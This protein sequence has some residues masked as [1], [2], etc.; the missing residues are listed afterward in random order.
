MSKYNLVQCTFDRTALRIDED[1]AAIT[2]HIR[3]VVEAAPDFLPVTDEGRSDFINR[4]SQWWG[5]VAP[6]V[7]SH[8]FLKESRFYEVPD[9]GPFPN[10]DPRSHMGDPVLV[11]TWN[12][13]GQ[14]ASGALP[15]QAAISVTLKT[16]H[17]LRWGRYYLPAPARGTMDDK[18]AIDVAVATALAAA[19]QK[20]TDRSGTGACATVFSRLHWN[21]EDPEK[22]QVDD[23][24]DV[25]RRRR[26]SSPLYRQLLDA[27]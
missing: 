5:G 14:N 18:G 3:Q 10:K 8:V 22:I 26:Y 12:S 23:I 27:G 17:R 13:V 1:D 11:H 4:L 15:P 24:F 16:A 9:G 2:F 19:T 20:L 6:H 21:H 7:T 25:I